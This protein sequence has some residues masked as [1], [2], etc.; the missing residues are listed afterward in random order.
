MTEER[1]A[2]AGEA[3]IIDVA[4]IGA[5]AAGLEAALVLGRQNRAAILFDSGNYR[6]ARSTG[7]H[8]LIGA[9][10]TPPADIR[11]RTLADLAELDTVE[12]RTTAV[13]GGRVDPDRDGVVLECA[14]G[15]SVFARRVI[16]A[17]GQRDELGSIPGLEESHGRH[18]FHCPY[19]HG[20]EARD[21]DILV[22]AVPGTPSMKAAYQA[23]Y[24]RDRISGRVR[25][26]ADATSLPDDLVSALS[27]TGV[28]LV[29][30]R[31]TRISGTPGAVDVAVDD[32]STLHCEV[33]FA[34]PPTSAGSDLGEILGAETSGACV[35]VD[36]HGR[37]SVPQV[38]AAGDCAVLRGEPEPLTF[39]G[40]AIG[41]GQ[42]AAV[43]A[44]QDLFM[45]DPRIPVPTAP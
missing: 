32:S 44:D 39:V 43:W 30:G 11:R 23:L 34:V 14:D 2:A 27:A 13:T 20:H 9:E 31:A 6:N 22:I 29:D 21:R 15:N 41:E 26:L 37:T 17:T 18:S 24:L 19:C 12:Y 28:G 1:P 42:K 25:L 33:L 10:G 7:A 45:S 36:G 16:I 3:D 40:Q 35:V 4:I 8:M 38:F 5:G